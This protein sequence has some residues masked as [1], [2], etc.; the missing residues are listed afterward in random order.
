MCHMAKRAPLP[1]PTQETWVLTVLWKRKVLHRG[2]C[3][4]GTYTSTDNCGCKEGCR[5]GNMDTATT[6]EFFDIRKMYVINMSSRERSDQ[7]S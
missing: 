6:K 4:S 2:Q 7:T 1:T 3:G 5:S